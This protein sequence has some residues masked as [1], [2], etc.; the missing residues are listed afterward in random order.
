[1]PNYAEG[2]LSRIGQVTITHEFSDTLGCL[3]GVFF[4]HDDHVIQSVTKKL[5][6]QVHLVACRLRPLTHK[7]GSKKGRA[8]Q[9]LALG[10]DGIHWPR[11]S[12]FQ[13]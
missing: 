13:S 1:M 9:A 3:N 4:S 12:G 10:I 2:G 5:G 11:P 8:H 7:H 6:I